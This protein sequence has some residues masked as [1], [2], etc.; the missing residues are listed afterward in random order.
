MYQLIIARY[1]KEDGDLGTVRSIYPTDTKLDQDEIECVLEDLKVFHKLSR[2]E[3]VRI[4]ELI[5]ELC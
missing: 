4:S 2:I 3:L 1:W 5:P